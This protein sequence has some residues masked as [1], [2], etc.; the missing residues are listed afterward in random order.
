MSPD[1]FK[2]WRKRMEWT[3]AQAGDALGLSRVHIGRLE[4]GGRRPISKAIKLATKYLEI[5][6]DT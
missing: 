1:E 3:Q 6:K 5:E 2:A 4:R